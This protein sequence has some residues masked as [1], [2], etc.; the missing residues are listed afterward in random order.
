MSEAAHEAIRA[1]LLYRAEQGRVSSLTLSGLRGLPVG[2][3]LTALGFPQVAGAVPGEEIGAVAEI[4]RALLAGGESDLVAEIALDA[5][6]TLPAAQ[7]LAAVGIA[8][9]PSTIDGSGRTPV[10][11][12]LTSFLRT[13]PAGATVVFPAGARYNVMDG[14]VTVRGARGVTFEFNGSTLE[15]DAVLPQRLRYPGR[16][17]FLRLLSTTDCVVR[18]MGV[19]GAN[20]NNRTLYAWADR[21]APNGLPMF[22]TARGVEHAIAPPSA[23]TEGNLNTEWGVYCLSLEFE[24]GVDIVDAK[25]LVVEDSCIT[26][27]FGDAVCIAGRS[28]EGVT[29]QRLLI[30][31]TGRQGIAYTGGSHLRADSCVITGAR[32][33]GI[34]IEPDYDHLMAHLSVT[35]CDV[36]SGLLALPAR[37][38]GEIEDVRIVGNRLHSRPSPLLYFSAA[39]GARRRRLVFTDNVAT[40]TQWAANVALLL[41][42]VDGAEIARN[43]IPF[44]GNRNATSYPMAAVGLRGACT[45]IKVTENRFVN[46]SP[47]VA[48]LDGSGSTFVATA[49]RVT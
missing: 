7:R 32:R 36:R 19:K 33:G 47:P 28:T 31:R 9:V 43:T 18:G 38:V 12:A 14:A 13:V 26:G 37:G 23:G 49:N 17:G 48:H 4:S 40:Q 34:D 45:A 41:E 15:R 2:Q 20:I 29:L 30:G 42:R 39:D 5:V 21:L 16:H 35:N 44:V 8:L 6:R 1:A 11:A 27:V 25:D 10:A 22:L 46:A 3:R 24:H